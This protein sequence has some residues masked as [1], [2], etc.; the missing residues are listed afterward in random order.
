ML[1]AKNARFSQSWMSVGRAVRLVQMLGLYALDVERGD[2][3]QVLPPAQD[4][5]ELEERR[6]TFWTAFYG[7]R[8][9]SVLTGWPTTINENEV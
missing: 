3:K 2:A 8:W 5:T 6:R 1:E 4:W 7:D 9:A